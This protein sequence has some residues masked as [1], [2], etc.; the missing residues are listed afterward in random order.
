[1]KTT[2]LWLGIICLGLA[3][4]VFVFAEG[5]RRWYSGGFFAVMGIVMLVNAYRWHR[6]S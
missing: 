4:A 1:M 5:L 3:V 2:G 6:T